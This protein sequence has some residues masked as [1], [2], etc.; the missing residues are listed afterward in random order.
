MPR[1][2]SA[3]VSA[4]TLRTSSST[5]RTLLPVEHGVGVV[6]LLEHPPALGRQRRLGPVQEQR[7][8]VEQPLRRARVLD[9][10]RLGVALEPRLL[11]AGQR[12]AGVDDHRDVA[13]ALVGLDPLEQLR[14]PVTF[15]SLRSSTMQSNGASSSACER[16]LAGAD[17][18]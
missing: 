10:D 13:A 17:R 3:L 7:R 15:G 16:L 5:I 11:A 4:N 12:L 1:A 18:R 6:Q 9:D 8:L 14:S 2:S